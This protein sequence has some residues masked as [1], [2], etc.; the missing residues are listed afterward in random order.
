VDAV[1]KPPLEAVSVEESHEELEVFFLA[2][3]GGRRHQ[4]EVAGE[5]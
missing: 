5:R 3:V 2:V 4:Q 1:A